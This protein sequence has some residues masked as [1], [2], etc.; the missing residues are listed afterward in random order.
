MTH[1]KRI[2]KLTHRLTG[3]GYSIALH[4]ADA[5][6]IREDQVVPDAI[7]A[8]QRAFETRLALA[9]IAAIRQEALAGRAP[10]SLLV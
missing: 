8:D 1:K 5:G 2:A 4:M 9:L 10:A 6:V 7:T 3:I